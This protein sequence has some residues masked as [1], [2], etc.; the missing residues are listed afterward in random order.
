MV[1]EEDSRVSRRPCLGREAVQGQVRE[2]WEQIGNPPLGP[3]I[4]EVI[5]WHLE[6]EREITEVTTR[7]TGGQGK[8]MGAGQAAGRTLR[9]KKFG[10]KSSGLGIAPNTER[11]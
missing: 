1:Q 2:G 6:K 8:L 10:W 3:G 11:K 5:G 9:E 4:L 7:H